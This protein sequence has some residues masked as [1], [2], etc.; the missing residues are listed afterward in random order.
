MTSAPSSGCFSNRGALNEIKL[1]DACPNFDSKNLAMSGY[2]LP[3]AMEVFQA[4]SR[5]KFE[6]PKPMLPGQPTETVIFLM[7][8][9]AAE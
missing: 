3:L 1:I 4:R 8:R 6:K 9:Y 5:K 7:I 2:E